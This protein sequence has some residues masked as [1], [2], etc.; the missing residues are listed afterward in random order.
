MTV[1]GIKTCGS[2]K[3]ALSFFKT[4]NIDVNF[5]DFKTTPVDDKKIS[6]WLTKADM[7]V[8]LNTKGTKYKTLGLSALNL[9]EDE[10]LSWLVQENLLIKR[11]VIECDDG[12]IIIGFD[13]VR[14]EEKFLSH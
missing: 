7:K 4:H 1:Y 12:S 6:S 14:Y 2:V 9:D 10:K 3:N 8:L 5:H 11:P 13:E